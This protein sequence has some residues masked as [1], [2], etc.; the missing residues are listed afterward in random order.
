MSE[1]T[2]SF[3]VRPGKRVRLDRWPTDDGRATPKAKDRGDQELQKLKVRLDRLQELLYADHTHAVLIVLQGM[4]T[5]GKDGTIRRV[6]E[7]VNP[8]GVRVESFKVPS[9]EERAH[10][11]LWRVHAR[12]PAKGQ[13][14]VFNRSH[15]EDVL[16]TRVH[17]LIPRATW[18]RRYDEINEFERT[19]T[20]EGT[21]ILKFYLHLS[22]G[23][24]RRRL[25][26]RLDDPAKHWKFREGDVT[27]RKFWKAYM[28]AYEDAI[29]ATS[30]SWAPWC[31]VPAD[32]KWYRDLVVCRRIVE[33]LEGLKM[34]FPSLPPE[35]H[36][37]RI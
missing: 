3:L 9:D 10:D 33:T 14:T 6:F 17:D 19:L 32:R 4:D 12:T 35:F 8:Q 21:I 5:A 29:T 7:G 34:R 25:Q 31:I 13:L 26:E 36:H 22:R 28:A 20:D 11:F 37:A 2:T 15:Y 27:E 23:E 24:Q 1:K 30:T 16:I 18:E